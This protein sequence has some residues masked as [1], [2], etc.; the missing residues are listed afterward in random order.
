MSTGTESVM[1][2]T[3]AEENDANCVIM[4]EKT[5]GKLL[6]FMEYIIDKHRLRML[7]AFVSFKD[8]SFHRDNL[9]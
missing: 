9:K 7:I 3:M 8:I 2:S 4:R 1:K 6:K 5:S